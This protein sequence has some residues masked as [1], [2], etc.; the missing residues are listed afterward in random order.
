LRQKGFG[1]WF[2]EQVNAPI[3]A[4]PDQLMLTADGK[5]N[6]VRPVQVAF[7]QNA[8][9]GPD[10]LRQRVAFALS[11]TWVVSETGGVNYTAYPPSPP[12]RF[13]NR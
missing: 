3:S 6:N 4:Y 7:F 8:L 11:E 1:T 2:A 5:N 13:T 9:N 12:D 10:Q